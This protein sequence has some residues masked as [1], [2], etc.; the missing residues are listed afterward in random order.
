MKEFYV[1]KESGTFSDTLECL[2]F[3]AILQKIFERIDRIIKPEII[4]E[5]KGGYFQ[6]TTDK[7][8]TEDMLLCCEY[9]DFIPYIANKKDKKEEL[10]FNF[11]DYEKEKE[12]RDIAYK[13]KGDKNIQQPRIDFDIVRTFAN[14]GERTGNKKV[15]ENWRKWKNDFNILVTFLLKYYNEDF[16]KRKEIA[17]KLEKIS[18]E[19]KI[20]CISSYQDIN[21]DKGKGVNSDKANSIKLGGIKLYWLPQMLRFAGAWNCLIVKYI[22][23]DFKTYALAPYKISFQRLNNIYNSLKPL[24]KPLVKEKD[25]IKIDI[26]LIQLTVI[27]LIK[28]DEKYN[29]EWS[30]GPINDK[31]AGFQFAYYKSLG[32]KPAVTNIGFLRL[33]NFVKFTS[34]KEGQHWIDI[35][36][37]HKEIISN[38]KESN[39]SNISMLQSYRQFIS[40]SDFEAFFEFLYGYASFIIAAYNDS[41]FYIKAFNLNNMEVLMASTDNYLEIIKNSGFISIAKAIRNCTIIPIIHKEKKDVIFGLNQKIKIASRT[42]DSLLT[43]I[44]EFVQNYNEMIMLKDYHNKAHKKYVTTED[45]QEFCSLFDGNYSPKLI[46]GLL[47]AI[48]YA[49]EPTIEYANEINN[50]NLD[51]AENE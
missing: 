18:E 8:I 3:V 11:I 23:K 39:S 47:V 45:I 49:K 51:G 33:P 28:Y 26:L 43:E 5:D 46:A 19:K 12:I 22:D 17:N 35:W 31:I 10:E 27:E 48:G 41:K 15:F 29:K 6:I 50:Q 30:F 38:I 7:V 2:G 14:I 37:E 9:F 13:N 36:N 20:A 24:L 40:A 32:N 44:A 42:K 34:E 4:I 1:F 21:P 25:S 16:E